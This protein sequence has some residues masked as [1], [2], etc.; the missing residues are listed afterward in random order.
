MIKPIEQNRQ[1]EL[2]V[3]IFRV[4]R[5]IADMTSYKNSL[6][7]LDIIRGIKFTMLRDFDVE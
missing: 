2:N 4:D 5:A 7:T 1:N 3:L 6:E